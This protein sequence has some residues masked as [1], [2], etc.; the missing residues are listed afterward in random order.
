MQQWLFRDVRD[1]SNV[2]SV[3]MVNLKAQNHKEARHYRIAHPFVRRGRG[4][5]SLG[6]IRGMF[7]SSSMSRFAYR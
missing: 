4:R 3:G 6:M 1:L 7:E 5:G 2:M